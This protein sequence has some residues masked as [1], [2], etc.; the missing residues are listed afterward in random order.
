VDGDSDL[1]FTG[2]LNFGGLDHRF[3]L[4]EHSLANFKATVDK[5]EKDSTDDMN[6]GKIKREEWERTK[7]L[8]DTMRLSHDDC[9]KL[10]Q[11]N[12]MMRQE[13][14]KQK[15]KQQEQDLRGRERI[16]GDKVEYHGDFPDGF[17]DRMHGEV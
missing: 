4:S 11:L 17:G 12:L 2:V 5:V 10:Y 9:Y 7:K 14:G 13:Q 6:A 15:R 16:V 3:D 1:G 8:C